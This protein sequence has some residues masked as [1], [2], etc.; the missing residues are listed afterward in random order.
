MLMPDQQKH[1]SLKHQTHP[2]LNN[3]S[4]VFEGAAA[5]DPSGVFIGLTEAVQLLTRNI[6]GKGGAICECPVPFCCI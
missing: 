6:A 4:S 2:E 5:V 1:A 3:G